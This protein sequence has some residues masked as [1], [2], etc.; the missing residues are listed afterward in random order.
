MASFSYNYLCYKKPSMH[1]SH[2]PFQ[3]SPC[4]LCYFS[5]YSLT[6]STESCSAFHEKAKTKLGHLFIT[7]INCT[8]FIEVIYKM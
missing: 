3:Q 6:N 7:I 4:S 2:F 5:G 1:G 8:Q